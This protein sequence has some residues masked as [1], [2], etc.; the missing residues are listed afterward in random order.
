MRWLGILIRVLGWLLTP[1]VVWAAS[2]YGAWLVIRF[3]GNAAAPR[4][5]VLAAVLGALA[6]G[7]AT[8]FLWMR[9]LRRSRRLRR[10][11]HVTREGLPLITDPVHPPHPEPPADA[12]PSHPAETPGE[13]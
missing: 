5:V 9:V 8:Q 6:V 13:S 3:A 12:T 2:V 1:L 11:L 4:R 7:G 10:S